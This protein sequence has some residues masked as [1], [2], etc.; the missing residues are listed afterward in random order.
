M[1]T[2]LTFV[3][4]LALFLGPIDGQAGESAK[5]SQGKYSP[6]GSGKAFS[7]GSASQAKSSQKQISQSKSSSSSSGKSI[8]NYSTGSGSKSSSSSSKYSSNSGKSASNYTTGSG[9]K[10]S[11]SSSKYLSA[12]GKS[13]SNYTTGSGSKYSSSSSRYS[14]AGSNSGVYKSPAAGTTVDSPKT[15]Y[16][17]S[18]S[19]SLK[20]ISPLYQP[21]SSGKSSAWTSSSSQTKKSLGAS[22]SRPNNT[23][24]KSGSDASARSITSR[25]AESNSGKRL[26]Y[27]KPESGGSAGSDSS[28]RKIPEADRS[29]KTESDKFG[30]S[31][32]EAGKQLGRS[33]GKQQPSGKS[34]ESTGRSETSS[35]AASHGKTSGKT[36]SDPRQNIGEFNGRPESSGSRGQGGGSGGGKDFSSL[37]REEAIKSASAVYHSDSKKAKQTYSSHKKEVQAHAADG[38]RWGKNDAK[39]PVD[40]YKKKYKKHDEKKYYGGVPYGHYYGDHIYKQRIYFSSGIH[41]GY[42]GGVWPSAWYGWYHHNSHWPYYG[43]YYYDRSWHCW[44]EEYIYYG[45]DGY[46]AYTYYYAG[47]NHIY[48]RRFYRRCRSDSFYFFIDMGDYNE[49][50]VPAYVIDYQRRLERRPVDV[51][52]ASDPV[53]RAYAQFATRNYYHSVVYFHDAIRDYPD[54]GLLYLARAQGYAAIKDYRSAY[55]DIMYGMHLIPDWP[56][57]RFNLAEIYSDPEEASKHLLALENWLDA[58]PEDWRA[59]FVLGYFRFFLQDYESAKLE[60]V[61]TLAYDSDHWQARRML[62]EIQERELEMELEQAGL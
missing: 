50:Y 4:A 24:E 40:E 3:A 58:H 28:W 46:Y 55:D 54:D 49:R 62:D 2:L 29:F 17:A 44:P 22:G 27:S 33:S 57:V 8:S 25:A 13:T 31:S 23:Y 15:G 19:K 9:S 34:Q 38:K 32:A 5:G 7:K 47:Y 52:D 61:Y 51:F 21:G 37:K 11:S 41:Y 26:T 39:T 12:S 48:P 6:G 56:E 18:P 20:K 35:S 60:L 53:S 45:D 43:Y 14:S 10:Y 30:R 59:H 16:A 36:L 1:K 42:Y